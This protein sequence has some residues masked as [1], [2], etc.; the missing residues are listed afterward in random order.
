MNPEAIQLLGSAQQI[1]DH[2]STSTTSTA[3]V[4]AFLARQAAEVMIEDRCATLVSEQVARATGRSKASILK[5]L[6]T[7]PAGTTLIRAWNQLSRY[8]H[9]HAYE[10]APS[11]AE[12]RA[13]CVQLMR[14]MEGEAA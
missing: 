4:A 5:S 6:D 1:L 13:M 3:R 8:C 2:S 10:L 9:E 14:V 11:V 12:V 7:T